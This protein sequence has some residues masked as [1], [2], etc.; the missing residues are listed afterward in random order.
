MR[1]MNRHLIMVIVP[2]MLHVSAPWCW[3]GVQE[4]YNAYSRGDYATALRELLP[5]AQQ[6]DAEA[7]ARLGSMYLWGQGVP[8]NYTEAVKWTQRAAEQG[9]AKAQANLGM[10]YH[11]G[12]GV[13]QSYAEAVKWTQRAAEQGLAQAQ[14][15]RGVM[16]K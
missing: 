9:H 1:R 7:Q 4:G 15:N 16:Y 5:L 3:A 11:E 13:P 10:M 12:Q 14:Q 8:Q 2:L 6:G